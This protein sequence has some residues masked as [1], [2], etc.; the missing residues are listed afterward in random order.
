M[1]RYVVRESRY[2]CV[3][4]NPKVTESATGSYPEQDTS[5]PHPPFAS[6]KMHFNIVLPSTHRYS[7]L[8]L[9]IS[10]SV[11]NL[12][13]NFLFPSV[14][15]MPS[16]SH[17]PWFD[18]LNK[19]WWTV[20][21]S[22][23][24]QPPVTFLYRRFQIPSSTLFSST[25]SLCSFVSM[26]DRVFE[27]LS[28]DVKRFDDRRMNDIRIAAWTVRQVLLAYSKN[29]SLFTLLTTAVPCVHLH[30]DFPER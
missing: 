28:F 22:V 26:K 18:H 19:V 14:C 1:T 27:F 6:F 20:Q 30:N 13:C 21:I 4:C 10:F 25:L 17:C 29:V 8:S 2:F 11:R 12:V 23:A 16:R 9:S 5:I 3:L 7:M 15:N 24:L